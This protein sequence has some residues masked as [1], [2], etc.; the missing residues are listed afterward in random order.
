V[1]SNPIP[2]SAYWGPLQFLQVKPCD[3]RMVLL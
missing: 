2:L 3:P 1:A